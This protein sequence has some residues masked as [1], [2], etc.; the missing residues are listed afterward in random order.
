MLNA[1][2]FCHSHHSSVLERDC[3]RIDVAQLRSNEALQ[4]QEEQVNGESSSTWRE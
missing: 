1:D 3:L 2:V 4:L